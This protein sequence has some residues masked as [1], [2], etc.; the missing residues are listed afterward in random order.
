V[1]QALAALREHPAMDEARAYVQGEADS[2]R[3]LLAGLPAGDATDALHEVCD[4][5]ASRDT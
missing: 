3:A 5:L 4:H 1:A 2:A